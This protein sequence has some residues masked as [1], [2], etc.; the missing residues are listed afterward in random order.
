MCSVGE[1]GLN[2]TQQLLLV[3]SNQSVSVYVCV[4]EC[5]CVKK[6]QRLSVGASV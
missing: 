5:V 6:G 3:P 1:M 2:F 4:N